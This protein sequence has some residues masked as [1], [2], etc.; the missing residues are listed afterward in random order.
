MSNILIDVQK[1][2]KLF[3]V[4]T[5]I[6][7]KKTYITAVDDVS[8]CI[9]DGEVLGL[10]GESGCGKSTIGRLL[11]KLIQPTSG[12]IWFQGKNIA[13]I[14]E[15]EM[16]PLRRNLQ[17]IFQDPY[18]S[19]NP[20]MT[21]G[22]IID[23]PLVI[24]TKMK[25]ETREERVKQLLELV[26]LNA[27]QMTRYPHEFSGGQKQRICIARA[28]AVEPKIII[29][30]E[31]VSS[32]DVSIQSQILNLMQDIHEEFNLS[33]LFIS[34]NLSVVKHISDRI[35][36]MYLGRIVEIGSKGS[37]CEMPAH[38]YT[39]ALLSAVPIANPSIKKERI[40]LQGDVP[41][42]VKPP[43]GCSFHA[44]CRYCMDI[45][46]EEKPLLKEVENN[47]KV[48]CHLY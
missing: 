37:V 15:R 17:M 1:L 7:R 20:R 36:V 46:K 27:K 47:H 39:K 2:K 23:E 5:G 42:L 45:C 3:P 28:L 9:N 16:Y 33:Y 10:V 14:S 12:E 25:F 38:P 31:P 6:L 26:G 19:L 43:K 34:H 11:L 35:C 18:E 32:L 41:N 44:R 13:Q 4:G 21:I 8:F 40:L 48:A 22:E 29:A 24:H 30:D